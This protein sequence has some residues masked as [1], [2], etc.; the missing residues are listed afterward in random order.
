MAI[1]LVGASLL[2]MSTFIKKARRTRKE[3]VTRR[4]LE[5][6]AFMMIIAGIATWLLA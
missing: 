4:V 3:P 1:S 6:L 5:L 2:F